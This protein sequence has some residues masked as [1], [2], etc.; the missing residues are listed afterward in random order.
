MYNPAQSTRPYKRVLTPRTAEDKPMT[1]AAPAKKTGTATVIYRPARDEP[2]EIRMFVTETNLV[3]VLFKAN[4]PM[5]LSYSKT[6]EQLLVE[7]YE[8]DEGIRSR[9]VERKV[10][11]PEVLK[12]NPSFEIDGVK[13]ERVT[14]YARMPDTA[15]GYRGYCINW[16]SVSMSADSMDKRW[17]GEEG[18]RQR[19]GVSPSD[20]AYLRPFFDSRRI[21]CAELDKQ[22][23]A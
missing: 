20:I 3:G 12:G 16:I 9:A 7:K 5:E 21:E 2:A 13:P 4:E 23:A 17:V 19:C 18:L 22:R 8:T 14:P 10:P 15:D 1:E 11:L 6:L